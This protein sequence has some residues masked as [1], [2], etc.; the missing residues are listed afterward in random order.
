MRLFRRLAGPAAGLAA[1][2]SLP[3]ALLTAAGAGDAGLLY[4]PPNLGQARAA[5]SE[6]VQ[7][8]AYDRAVAAAARTGLETVQAAVAA[9][10]PG[11]LRLA[12]VFD[13]DE[14]ALSNI[15]TVPDKGPS[16]TSGPCY[17]PAAQNNPCVWREWQASANDR[18]IVPVRQIADFARASDVAVFFISGRP[19]S[20]REKTEANL[21]A[22]GYTD[23]QGLTLVPDGRTFA[24]AVDYKAPARA[25]I[26]A[27][28][29]VIVLSVGDQYSD[30]LGG[31]AA[32]TVKLPNP[33]YFI[34]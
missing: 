32:N 31:H 15:V 7:S 25:A 19:E 1:G 11:D 4:E 13:L 26:E 27:Q 28:G 6:W 5:V 22:A 18:P 10:K 33:F 2:L 20:L 29:Y 23:Y 3:F 17:L 14:T 8:G 12:V 21:K 16:L 9:R 34:P 30:L 24:S